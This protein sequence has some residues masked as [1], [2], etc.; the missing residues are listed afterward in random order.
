M[1]A[2]SFHIKSVPLNMVV[3]NLSFFIDQGSDRKKFGPQRNKATSTPSR[4]TRG[5]GSS[6]GVEIGA[7]DPPV[8][9]R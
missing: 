6:L 3:Q 9:V 4:P 8:L 7:E 1:V 5:K 2:R